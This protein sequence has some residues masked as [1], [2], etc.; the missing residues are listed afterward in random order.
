MEIDEFK[1]YLAIDLQSLKDLEIRTL[2]AKELYGTLAKYLLGLT[3]GLIL[4]TLVGHCLLV[5]IGRA[6]GERFISTLVVSSVLAIG[7]SIFYSLILSQAFLKYII[8]KQSIMPLLKTGEE[9]NNKIINITK[10]HIGV[11]LVILLLSTIFNEHIA[12]DHFFALLGTF[13]ISCI[14]IDSE[15]SRIGI[16]ELPGIIAKIGEGKKLNIT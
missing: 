12:F 10:F 16:P 3:L 8:F 1:K 4:I 13:F 6:S 2:S 14:F 5:L 9:L 15:L 7:W 11:Y